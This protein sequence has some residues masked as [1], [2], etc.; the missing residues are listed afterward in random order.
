VNENLKIDLIILKSFTYRLKTKEVKLKFFGELFLTQSQNSSAKIA[1]SVD[2]YFQNYQDSLHKEKSYDWNKIDDF[3]FYTTHD[4]F[5]FMSNAYYFN[6]MFKIVDNFIP[7]G[8][9]SYLI[10]NHYTR[11]WKLKE[12]ESE[13]KVLNLSDLAF[14][15]NIWLSFCLISI[16]A[17][18]IENCARFKERRRVVKHAKVHPI[19]STNFRYNSYS[20]LKLDVSE[21]FRIR[22]KESFSVII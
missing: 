7:T 15:F 5:I 11:K 18:I 9:M 1:L 19:Q 14:G 22:K 16:L 17:F 8:I 12:V 4:V 2:D 6:M 13:P 3:V 20:F 21:K 10:E